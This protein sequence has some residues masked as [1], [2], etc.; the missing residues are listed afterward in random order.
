MDRWTIHKKK[1]KW[2]K[3]KTTKGD[4]AIYRYEWHLLFHQLH[5]CRLFLLACLVDPRKN[6]NFTWM[7]FIFLSNMLLR[8]FV[9]CYYTARVSAA[10][11]TI[12][13]TYQCW[14]SITLKA[15]WSALQFAYIL[16]MKNK[17]NISGRLPIVIH[18]C[19]IS[20]SN[21]FIIF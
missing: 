20:V 6:V 5:L 14:R 4:A 2:K 17:T 13:Y 12:F 19:S 8:N 3:R 1:R 21:L 18:R 7:W 16:S 11:E 9:V 10:W 15:L